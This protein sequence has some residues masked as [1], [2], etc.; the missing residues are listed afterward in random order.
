[1]ALASLCSLLPGHALLRQCKGPDAV[2]L[3]PEAHVQHLVSLVQHQVAHFSCHHHNNDHW[4]AF[5]G[6]SARRWLTAACS[7]NDIAAQ[8]LGNNLVASCGYLE[9]LSTQELRN[10]ESSHGVLIIGHNSKPSLRDSAHV[11]MLT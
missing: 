9:V 3:R 2:K 7:L 6:L 4:L 11:C 5:A 8:L 10:C 1:M